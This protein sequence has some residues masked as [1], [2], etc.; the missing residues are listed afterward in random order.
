MP[1]RRFTPLKAVALMIPIV[2]VAAAVCAW[3]V[4]TRLA[5][6]DKVPRN[7]T[8][9]GDAIGGFGKEDLE[10]HVA[11]LSESYLE[12]PVERTHEHPPR[13]RRHATQQG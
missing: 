10:A 3:A 11:N 1:R 8:L 6:G 9:A 5:N 4:D 2:I 7:V 13:R 12:T